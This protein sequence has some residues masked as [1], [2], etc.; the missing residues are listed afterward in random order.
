MS[1]QDILNDFTLFQK[2]NY[3]FLNYNYA[4]D[5]ILNK[6]PNFKLQNYNKEKGYYFEKINDTNIYIINVSLLS[7]KIKKVNGLNSI[8]NF[9]YDDESKCDNIRKI[10]MNKKFDLIDKYN[11]C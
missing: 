3:N 7:E 4:L 11:L 2:K 8:R 9:N 6:Y 10:L 5:R 1:D